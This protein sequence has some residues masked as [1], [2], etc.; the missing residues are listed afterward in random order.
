MA[1]RAVL[2]TAI[3]VAALAVGLPTDASAATVNRTTTVVR[4]APVRVTTTP[5]TNVVR[6]PLK[7]TV[8]TTTTT[9]N[10]QYRKLNTGRSAGWGA[11]QPNCTG[12]PRT[13]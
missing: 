11:A 5:R 6:T 12:P 1:K 4:T 3:S 10:N 7:T 9:T 2:C 8:R 13:S